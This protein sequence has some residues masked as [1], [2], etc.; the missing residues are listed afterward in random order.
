VVE[1]PIKKYIFVCIFI[2]LI[3]EKMKKVY[4]FDTSLRDGAQTPWINLTAEDKIQIA[5]KI[6]SLWIDFIEAG[7]AVSSPSD[8]K[9]IKTIVENTENSVIYS[10]ARMVKLDIDVAYDCLKNNMKKAWLHTFIWTSP[11]HREKLNMTKKQILETIKEYLTYIKEKFADSDHIM[12]SPEDALRTEKDFLF[13]VVK[14]AV[15]NGANEINIPDTVWYAQPEEINSIIWELVNLYPDVNFSI[16]CHND[17]WNASINSLTALKAGANIVQ[18]TIPPLFWERAGNADLL[19]VLMNIKKRQDIYD[20]DIKHIHF[21]N[22]YPTVQFVENI[23]WKR[24]PAHYPI[25]GRLVH[26]HSSWIHQDG[27]NKNKKTYEII[28]PEEIG[29]KIEQS[30][31]LTN[32]SWRWGLLSAIKTYFGIDLDTESLNKIFVKFKELASEKKHI[33]MQDIKH[34]LQD[35]WFKINTNIK[36]KWWEIKIDLEDEKV[37]ANIVFLDKE[38]NETFLKWFGVGPVDVIISVFNKY[39]E[40]KNPNLKL[41]ILDFQ[42]SALWTSSQAQAQVYIKADINWQIMEEYGLDLDIVKATVKAC[43]S[44]VNR[45]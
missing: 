42:I 5:K 28:A 23:S 10:L 8:Q 40:E 7:F 30:F 25:V 15:E 26:S 12:F 43:M 6:E 38:N 14:V 18:W 35:E 36:L 44:L 29:M 33:S 19:Q 34:L 45:M 21:E 41:K 20:F 13:E 3:I 39:L 24:I 37:Q 9:A 16:H 4:F 2:N 32:Q 17:L 31:I 27:V 1:N 11:L 22:F